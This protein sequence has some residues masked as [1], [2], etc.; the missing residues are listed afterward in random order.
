MF[1]VLLYSLYSIHCV[2]FIL[3]IFDFIFSVMDGVS[4]IYTN[5]LWL[6]QFF[7]FLYIYQIVKCCTWAFFQ[8][9][10]AIIL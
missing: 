4:T 10:L 8:V 3:A 5:Y 9:Q 6:Y 1:F 7:D 2:F